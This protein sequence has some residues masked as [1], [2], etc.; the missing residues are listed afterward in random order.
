MGEVVSFS[1]AKK[2]RVRAARRRQADANAA[3]FGLTHEER[4]AEAAKRDKE[5]R[6]LDQKRLD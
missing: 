4:R 3:R 5:R 1:K 6:D 2:L